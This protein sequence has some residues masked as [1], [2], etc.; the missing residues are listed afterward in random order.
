MTNFVQTHRKKIFWMLLLVMLFAIGV[1]N[2]LT[3]YYTD[4][5]FYALEARSADSL[6]EL[7]R[8]QYE[9]YMFHNCRVIGQF[10]IRLFLI[11]EK[12]W[13]NFVNSFMFIALIL[14]LYAS[15]QNRKKYDLFL[16][17]LSSLLVWRYSACFGETTLWLSGS[18][19]Y[20]WGSV[21]IMG[22]LTWYRY[23][24]KH[25]DTQK[26]SAVTALCCY[27]F[28]LAAGW[29]NENT[30][31]GAFLLVLFFTAVHLWQK[32]G[33]KSVKPF[34]VTSILGVFS[35]LAA[36]TFCPG[37]RYRLQG[38]EQE[39]FTGFAGLLSRIYKITVNMRE[40]YGELLVILMVVL[41][42]LVL[43]RKQYD[44]KS[45]A[46]NPIVFFLVAAA[47]TSYVLVLI[48]PMTARAHYGTGIFIMAA[49][50]EAVTQ[51][52]KE[53]LFVKTMQYGFMGVLCL[54]LFSSYFENLVNLYRIHR[55]S[56]ERIEM[57]MEAKSEH[58]ESTQVVVPQLRTQFD[59]PYS[60]AY[61][62]DLSEDPDFWIN[63]FYEDYYG[64]DSVIAIP[65]QEWDELYGEGE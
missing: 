18:C 16:L 32:N 64:V 52:D 8:Q 33:K 53:E 22:F 13:F 11:P 38:V 62:S 49:F 9:E 58:G 57:I 47:A 21:I 14:L 45:L 1:Y 24:L 2:F 51:L 50:L 25:A 20:L 23:L 27:F 34:M 26:H 37:V 41:V 3:P 15:V 46:T 60:A 59:N 56:N 39:N 42:L 4:D 65:R 35:G 31:G 43:Q 61:D 7:I 63:R 44:W 30:S 54:W 48:P 12:I 10:N 5:L 19:N 6:W 17:L 55:E 28:G 29:C 40:L 36:M